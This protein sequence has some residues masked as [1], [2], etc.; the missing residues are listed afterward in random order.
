MLDDRTPEQVSHP[1]DLDAMRKKLA[2]SALT[3]SEKERAE[4]L[5]WIDRKLAEIDLR[6]TG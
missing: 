6:Q 4:M 1:N 3:L 2:L 5:A